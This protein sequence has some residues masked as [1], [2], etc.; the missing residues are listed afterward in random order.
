MSE[1]R[2]VIQ[3]LCRVSA[4]P[5]T[6]AGLREAYHEADAEVRRL[7]LLALRGWNAEADARAIRRATTR[8][9]ALLRQIVEA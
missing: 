6:V 8:R 5:L 4:Q 1:T 9:D 7:R 2:V 3:G